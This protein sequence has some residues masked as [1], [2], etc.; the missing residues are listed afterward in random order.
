MLN[1]VKITNKTVSS[2]SQCSSQN[3]I[4]IGNISLGQRLQ[5]KVNTNYKSCNGHFLEHNVNFK[6][7]CFLLLIKMII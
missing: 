2:F 4:N 3:T 6:Q 5:T 1:N 7:Q